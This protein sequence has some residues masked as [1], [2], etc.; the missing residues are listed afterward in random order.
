MLAEVVRDDDRPVCVDDSLMWIHWNSRDGS[1]NPTIQFDDT[2]AIY[3]RG[4][5]NDGK[6]VLATRPTAY[7][8][9]SS[10][11]TRRSATSLSSPTAPW[12]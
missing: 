4:Q 8:Q 12:C 3:Y 7:G 11:T 2:G 6:T 1:G 5:T 9:T 10:P